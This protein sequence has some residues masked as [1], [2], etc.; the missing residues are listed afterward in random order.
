M[1]K[2]GSWQ[3]KSRMRNCLEKFISFAS[4]AHVSE[5]VLASRS[6]SPCVSSILSDFSRLVTIH[7]AHHPHLYLQSPCFS[8]TVAG[9]HPSCLVLI[10]PSRPS[11]TAVFRASFSEAPSAASQICLT[12][13]EQASPG[14]ALVST[15]SAF[16]AQSTSIA[17]RSSA[18]VAH[19]LGIF[20][21]VS[22]S[23]H[24][25]SVPVHCQQPPFTALFTVFTWLLSD[26]SIFS[27]SQRQLIHFAPLQ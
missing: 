10:L 2:R 11:S 7:H 24:R 17:S 12:S 23:V 27:S 3:R 26:L 15:L 13:W 20:V 25:L 8:I 9:S 19:R 4:V 1:A 22:S 18:T 6:V 21:V 5:D 14:L 16:C